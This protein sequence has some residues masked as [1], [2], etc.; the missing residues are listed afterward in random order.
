MQASERLV[1]LSYAV[2]E[3]FGLGAEADSSTTSS[4]PQQQQQQQQAY[5][6]GNVALSRLSVGAKG[7][8][9]GSLVT[10]AAASVEYTA[11]APLVVSTLKVRCR[12][13]CGQNRC[14]AEGLCHQ[15]RCTSLASLVVL[16]A[17]LNYMLASCIEICGFIA[18]S[19]VAGLPVIM[20]AMTFRCSHIAR[21]STLGGTDT[22]NA[23]SK[24]SLLAPHCNIL[25]AA[26]VI[27]WY[28]NMYVFMCVVFAGAE[29]AGGCHLPG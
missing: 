12:K 26:L 15:L 9:S 2:L 29:H 8:S 28:R 18:H 21:C 27:G 25:H 4:T 17:G 16:A 22:K 24:R 7:G 19:L 23:P 14:C 13:L 5:S 10:I 1:A 20:G 3:R 6:N 11:F